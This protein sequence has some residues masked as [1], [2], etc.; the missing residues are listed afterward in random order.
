MGNCRSGMRARHTLRSLARC[1]AACSCGKF[2]GLACQLFSS[3]ALL[4]VVARLLVRE[5]KMGLAMVVINV[6]RRKVL[7]VNPSE[8]HTHL[9]YWTELL[10]RGC[11]IN[12][13]PKPRT[14]DRDM[15]AT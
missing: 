11:L 12:E 2:G 1:K 10:F 7:T 14:R 9:L 5:C 8:A 6:M 3:G 15:W 13:G 4:Q